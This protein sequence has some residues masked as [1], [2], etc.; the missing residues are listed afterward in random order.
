MLQFKT[1]IKT[2]VDSPTM[3]PMHVAR[4]NHFKILINRT[5]SSKKKLFPL[6]EQGK[7]IKCLSPLPYSSAE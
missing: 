4:E 3:A 5:D 7:D 6:H 1:L 2:D